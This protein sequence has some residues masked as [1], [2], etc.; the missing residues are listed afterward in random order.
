MNFS[1]V[2]QGYCLLFR[3]IAASVY[4]NRDASQLSL[5]FLGNTT[6]ESI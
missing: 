1:D 5:Y 3:N 4:L 2:F 6:P